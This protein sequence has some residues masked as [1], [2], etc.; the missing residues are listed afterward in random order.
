[1]KNLV[2][3]MIGLL[4][5][6]SASSAYAAELQ[7]E[8]LPSLGQRGFGGETVG[9]TSSYDRTPEGGVWVL[10]SKTSQ[11]PLCDSIP[12]KGISDDGNFAWFFYQTEAPNTYC[13]SGTYGVGELKKGYYYYYAKSSQ[14]TCIV[15]P[16]EPVECTDGVVSGDEEGFDCG[17]SCLAECGCPDG[18]TSIV[19]PN[20]QPSD[21]RCAFYTASIAGACPEFYTAVQSGAVEG[22]ECY[23]LENTFG[24][25]YPISELP[26]VEAP[27]GFTG[28]SF[29]TIESTDVV[30]V[31]NGDG[32]TTITETTTI[33]NNSETI[34]E[35]TSTTTVTRIIDNTTGAVQSEDTTITGTDSALDNP[36]NYSFDGIGDNIYDADISADLPVELDRIGLVDNFIATSPF[37]SAL[38]SFEVQTSNAV[39]NINL[40]NIYGQDMI[41]DFCA[42]ESHLVTFGALF[43]SIV[44]AFSILVIYRGWK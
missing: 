32:T 5:A 18:T 43:L 20:G 26:T 8:G 13:T 31:D 9:F 36:D 30:T 22:E 4:I 17:G 38:N 44:Q 2:A 6:V 40:G 25:M 3:F 24:F 27:P 15:T 11:Y 35:S 23:A 34:N 42:W 14:D 33:T 21:N 7:C 12:I 19:I 28:G 10:Q 39:C 41:V 37:F 1:M 29:N 16:T